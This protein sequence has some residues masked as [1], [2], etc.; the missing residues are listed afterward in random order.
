MNQIL[1]V[2]IP[3][4][5]K[6]I[7][8]KSQKA[9]IKSVIRFFCITTII[10]SITIIG[11]GIWSIM[12][13]SSE[14]KNE[15]TNNQNLDIPKIYVV[16]NS[17][18]LEVDITTK[19][20]IA[21]VKYRWN[22]EE[23]QE[24]EGDG[25]NQ[26]SI[27][28]PIPAGTNVFKIQVTDEQGKSNEFS[29]SY[30]GTGEEQTSNNTQTQE[31]TTQSNE[32]NINLNFAERT[33][34]LNVNCEEEKKIKSITYFYDNNEPKVNEVNDNKATIQIPVN[35]G[36]HILTIKV[37][38]E[39]N[40]EKQISKKLYFP[41]VEKAQLSTDGNSIIL[42]AS[43]VRKITKVKINLNGED[44]P[45]ETVNS[46]KFEKSIQLKEGENKIILTVFNTD[47]LSITKG[48]KYEKK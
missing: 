25:N 19:S 45:E 43:D 38:Y 21:S 41:V 10:F 36:E 31:Q 32:P 44:L 48:T 3:K 35:Q 24:Q 5:T 2:D 42:K 1:S 28:I 46:E 7:H 23:I 22:N 39:D 12:K 33:N 8:G 11:V 4:K 27:N 30:E 15:I 14:N 34:Y 16:Q 29:N 9:N 20:P 17:S 6:R 18:E 13:N 37:T 40:T 47:G 26:L